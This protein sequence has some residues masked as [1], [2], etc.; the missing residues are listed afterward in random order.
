MLIA[1]SVTYREGDVPSAT[2]QTFI[3]S[4]ERTGVPGRLLPR[5]RS[6]RTTAS[7]DLANGAP[8]GRLCRNNTAR[9][10]E[11]RAWSLLLHFPR[12]P[13]R[14]LGLKIIW[15]YC[16]CCSKCV[17]KGVLAGDL[18]PAQR[19]GEPTAGISWAGL[20]KDFPS[21]CFLE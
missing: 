8:L 19:E 18:L 9:Q 16:P 7:T 21:T 3:S 13:S 14:L 1:L 15:G 11:N 4:Y 17:N 20:Q 2:F 5:V 10:R 12:T 6:G